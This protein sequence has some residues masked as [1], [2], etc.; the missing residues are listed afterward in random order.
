MT[1]DAATTE[2]KVSTNSK[3]RDW[4]G[5]TKPRLRDFFVYAVFQVRIYD[6]PYAG[7][8]HL[9]LFGGV[10]IQVIGTAINLQQMALFLPFEL[11]FPRGAGYLIY[12][13]LMDLAGLAILIGVALA[14]FR[15][16]VI[17]PKSLE[18]HWDDYYALV[19][20]T[21]IPLIGFTMEAM[22]LI[23]ASPDWYAWSPIGSAFAAFYRALGLTPAAAVAVRSKTEAGH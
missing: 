19:M 13:L 22:R 8:M 10:T 6:K 14:A 20:L 7:I 9:L 21:L 5:R 1:T 15:R 18:S 23:A 12:E 16:L 17:R 11:A 4:W 2:P 3:S